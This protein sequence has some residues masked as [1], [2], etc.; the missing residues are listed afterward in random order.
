MSGMVENGGPDRQVLAGRIAKSLQEARQYAAKAQKRHNGLSLTGIFSSG[1]VTLLTGW[2][3]AAGP[4]MGSGIDAWRATCIVAAVL[5]FI[6]TAVMSVSQQMNL[7]ERM[8][9]GNECLGRLRSL[10]VGLE[11]GSIA[12]AQAAGEYAAVLKE[13]PQILA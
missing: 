12:P 8:R 11:L 6:A 5:G 13:Y 4:V 10:E 3:S 2:T 7:G 9:Q 1:V